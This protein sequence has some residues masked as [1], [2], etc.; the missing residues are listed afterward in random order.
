MFMF[1][2]K[3]DKKWSPFTILF[4][5]K[6]LKMN[7]FKIHNILSSW[8]EFVHIS[9]MLNVHWVYIGL[10]YFFTLFTSVQDVDLNIWFLITLDIWELLLIPMVDEEQ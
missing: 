6:T 9:T 8:E 2:D 4:S 3:K 5:S 1:E 10:S 7:Y